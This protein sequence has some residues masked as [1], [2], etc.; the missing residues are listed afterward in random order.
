MALMLAGFKNWPKHRLLYNFGKIACGLGETQ[1][2][3]I[4]ERVAEGVSKAATE[5]REHMNNADSFTDMG[6]KMLSAWDRG[7]MRS[8]L[9][10]K[11]PRVS[12]GNEWQMSLPTALARASVGEKCRG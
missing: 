12:L 4:L 5:L 7:M 2:A 1:V 8:L 6:S 9:D 10:D 11:R 3:H